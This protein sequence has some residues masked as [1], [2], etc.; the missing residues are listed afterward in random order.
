MANHTEPDE[1]TKSADEV[2]NHSADRPA[3][4]EEATAAESRFKKSDANHRAEVA[5]H[6]EEMMEIGVETKG[7]GAFD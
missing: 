6:E 3:T 2:G 7:E 4:E 1:A 5:R